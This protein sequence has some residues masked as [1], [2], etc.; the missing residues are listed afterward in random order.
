MNQFTNEDYL[1]RMEVNDFIDLDAY[2]QL[3]EGDLKN[4]KAIVDC[5]ALEL[6][7]IHHEDIE[8]NLMIAI[9]IEKLSTLEEKYDDAM[10]K[11]ENLIHDYKVKSQTIQKLIAKR[12]A[13]Y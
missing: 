13:K 1:F 9:K 4:Q 7:D 5:Y 2:V 10:E 12:M 3:V 6:K 8:S 11:F